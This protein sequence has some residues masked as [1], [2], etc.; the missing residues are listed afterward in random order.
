RNGPGG[1][2]ITDGASLTIDIDDRLDNQYPPQPSADGMMTEI[3]ANWLNLDNGTLIRK[4][5][6]GAQSGGALA[7]GTSQGDNPRG[8]DGGSEYASTTDISLTNGGRI[9]NDGQM[10]FGE[11]DPD[12]LT[13]DRTITMTINDGSVDLTGGDAPLGGPAVADLIFIDFEPLNHTYAIN[14]TGP[15]SITVDN[16]IISAYQ[17][18]SGFPAPNPN[19]WENLDLVTYEDLWDAGLLQFNGLSGLD[20][21]TFGDYFTVTGVYNAANYT[22][23]AD[24]GLPGDFDGDGDVDGADFLMWQRGE[25]PSPLSTSDLDDWKANFGTIPSAGTT[26]TLAVPEPA[27][28][29]LLMLAMAA[30]PMR[31]LVNRF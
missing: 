23:T 28:L 18:Y 16:G 7:F 11:W 24:V 2:T 4:K 15:G 9:E 17:P 21:E 30:M 12:H 19:N 26:N 20:G 5:S 3:D 14:F 8:G 31:Q 22:L 10:W 29:F 27:A 6:G 25:S 13:Y 1:L